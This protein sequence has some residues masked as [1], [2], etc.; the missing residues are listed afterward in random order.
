V[1]AERIVDVVDDRHVLHV[2]ERLALQHACVAEK[3]FEFFGAILGEGRGARLFVDLEVGLAEK[4][5][6]LV[7]GIIEFGAVLDRSGDDQRRARL[8]HED[9]IDLVDDRVIMAALDHRLEI[10]LHV[11]AQIVEAE[12]VV[13]PV[14]DVAGIGLAALLLREA[15]D[16]DADREAE[17]AVDAAHPFGVALGQVVV[18][19]D[20]MDAAAGQRIQVDGE[21]S[22][23]RLALAGLHLGDGALVQDHPADQLDVEMALA[24][25]ALRRFAYRREGGSQEIVDRC[26]GRDLI[27][28]SL[29]A[30]AELVVGE[31]L[32]VVFEGV[33]RLHHRP[34]ALDAPIARGPEDLAPK[35]ADAEHEHPSCAIESMGRR[36]GAMPAGGAETADR[37]GSGGGSRSGRRAGRQIRTARISVNVR[38]LRHVAKGHHFSRKER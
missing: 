13:G 33:D 11:V 22:D 20:D 23:E 35:I 27:A 4:R 38:A 5:N 10:V 21:G 25:G 15:V 18:D 34:V 14:G 19:G 24:E 2:V 1:G 8:V 26:P 30:G 12:L 3:V 29:G 7:D 37:P 32:E 9:G 28:K 16:D 6:E 36:S 31:A 17:E